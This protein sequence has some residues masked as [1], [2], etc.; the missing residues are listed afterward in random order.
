MWASEYDS[1]TIF[2]VFLVC[3]RFGLLIIK[4]CREKLK[5][6]FSTRTTYIGEEES[7]VAENSSNQRREL[8]PEI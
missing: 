8:F 2:A 1:Y 4:S 6:S 5:Y 3:Y 7:Y